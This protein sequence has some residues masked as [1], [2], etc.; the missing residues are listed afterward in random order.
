MLENTGKDK[1][2]AFIIQPVKKNEKT[3]HSIDDITAEAEGLAH[4]IYLDVLELHV[5]PYERIQSNAFFGKGKL[6]EMAERIEKLSPSIVI[7]NASLSPVQ[8]RNLETKWKCKVI[9]RTG[10]ILEIFGERAQTKEGQLQVDLAALEYQ[11]SRLVRSWTHLERQRGGAGFMGGPGERQIELDRRIIGQKITSIKKELEDVRR[12]R[13]LGRKNRSR[14]PFPVCSF[15]GY[16]NAGKSTL[17]NRLT[18]AGVFAEDL[19]FAT[20]DPTLRKITL[21][22]KH[23]VILADTV[24]FI[25][26]LPT[27]LVEAFR[28]T[29]EQI[30]YSDVILHIAD[31]SSGNYE[32]QV[33]DVISVLKSLGVEY[34]NDP[35]IIEVYNKIDAVKN[36]GDREEFKRLQNRKN[37]NV[38]CISALTGEGIDDLLQKIVDIMTAQY[39]EETITLPQSNGKAQ[40]WIYDHMEVL[41]RE[42]KGETVSF[43]VRTDKASKDKFSKLFKKKA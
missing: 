5:A 2:T 35:R 40:S 15:V 10:L 34:E 9:D 17:F 18:G 43:R 31:V 8:Q 28:A 26:D 16:T 41:K 1:E 7:V 20:L 32:A 38:V 36:D 27:H 22:N 25:S 24:G 33:E 19:P 42:D 39:V 13:E 30:I 3:K 21:P 14:V 37:S 11:K 6:E 12:T 29:L 23:D 4:A